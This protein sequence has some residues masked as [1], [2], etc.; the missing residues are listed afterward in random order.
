MKNVF[1]LLLAVA[2]A[3]ACKK[4]GGDSLQPVINVTSPTANQ[5]FNAGQVINIIATISDNDQLHEVHLFV[6]NKAT[7]A[8]VVH[9]ADHV[10][11][12]TYNINQT[13]TAAANVTYKIKIEANDHWGNHAEVEF[14]VR[15]N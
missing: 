2:C 14:E 13:L 4:N 15:G 9:F 8:D 6:T 10:D 11:V 7:N 5:Q 3:S 1:L 12:S